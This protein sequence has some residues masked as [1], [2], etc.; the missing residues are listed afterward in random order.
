MNQPLLLQAVKK[1]NLSSEKSPCI[2]SPEYN[3]F[4]DCID[5]KVIEELGCRPFWSKQTGNEVSVCHQPNQY[6]RHMERKHE[7]FSMDEVKLREE[8]GC[9]KS[10]CYMEYK[11]IAFCVGEKHS[12]QQLN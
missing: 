4:A 2:S 8:F 11:V 10:C 6:Q 12:M 3:F 1:S 5:N 9:V 7:I